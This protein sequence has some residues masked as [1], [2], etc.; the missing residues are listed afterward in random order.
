MGMTTADMLRAE[1][2]AKGLGKGAARVLVRQLTRKFGPVP[3]TVRERI[4]AAPIEQLDVWCER[5]LDAKRL[6]EVFG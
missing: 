4:N 6:D 3:D 1:G 2:E 5:V